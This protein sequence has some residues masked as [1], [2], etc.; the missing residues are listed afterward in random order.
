VI[1]GWET[2]KFDDPIIAAL[3]GRSNYKDV[4]RRLRNGTFHYQPSLMPQKFTDFFQ[5]KDV[6]LWLI[7]LHEEFCRF[8]RDWIDG[9]AGQTILKEQIREGKLAQKLKEIGV[10]VLLTIQIDSVGRKDRVIPSNVA[11]AA[12]FYQHDGPFVRGRSQI[13]AEDSQKT[14]IL[15]NFN[16]DYKHK[17]PSR[18]YQETLDFYLHG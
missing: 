6:T 10:P 8:M 9:V 14:A 2:A 13:V 17:K 4:L 11:R 18:I 15:G 7:T 3:L 5:S 1:E 16:H 12:N